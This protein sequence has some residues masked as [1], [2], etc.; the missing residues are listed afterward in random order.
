MDSRAKAMTRLRDFGGCPNF[1]ERRG[2]TSVKSLLSIPLIYRTFPIERAAVSR[3]TLLANT[4]FVQHQCSL[5]TPLQQPLEKSH[6]RRIV[7]PA[8]IR[9]IS[10]R[11]PRCIGADARSR[12]LPMTSAAPSGVHIGALQYQ[13]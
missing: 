1:S 2:K 12:F 10:W 6:M 11:N 4:S 3:G 5:G 8:C 13:P 9:N 7:S